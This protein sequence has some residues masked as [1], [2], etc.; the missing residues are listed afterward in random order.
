MRDRGFYWAEVLSTEQLTPSFVRVRFG[1]PDLDDY[2]AHESPDE[3]VAIYFPNPGED[4]PP[5]MTNID[6]VWWFHD[7]SDRPEGRNYTVRRIEPDGTLVVD[8]VAHEGGVAASW[9]QSASAGDTV[10][11]S[12]PRGWYA[13]PEDTDWQLLVADLAGLPALARIVEGLPKSARAHVIAEVFDERDV[14]HFDT[15]GAVT[16]DWLVGSGNGHGPGAVVDAVRAWPIPEGN[17]YVWFAGEA[18]DSRAVRKFVRRERGMGAD[19]FDIIGYWRVRAEQWLARYE[20]VESVVAA[21]YTT[22]LEQ[23][24]TEK[25]A[26]EAYDEMLEKVGL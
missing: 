21:A 24:R 3:S 4:R 15:V 11:F 12:M 8:F 2:D 13:V 14:L 7:E 17:G 18:A 1:G 6:G 16:V 23:G 9:A 19:R 22:A 26:A 10:L 20:K 25:E 5:A